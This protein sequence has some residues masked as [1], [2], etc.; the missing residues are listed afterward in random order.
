MQIDNNSNERFVT[1]LGVRGWTTG[2]TDTIF[3]LRVTLR[4]TLHY[5]HFLNLLIVTD[6][7]SA[8]QLKLNLWRKN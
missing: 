8:F 5:R 3:R 1:A 2:Y 6:S 4:T 7:L